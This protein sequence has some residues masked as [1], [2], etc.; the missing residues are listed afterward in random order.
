[1]HRALLQCYPY[2]TIDC[3]FC[4]SG[5]FDNRC[6]ET[7]T[8]QTVTKAVVWGKRKRVIKKKVSEA[9]SALGAPFGIWS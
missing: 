9:L 6:R 3:N 2:P 1:M 8:I 5:K 7:L 4:L